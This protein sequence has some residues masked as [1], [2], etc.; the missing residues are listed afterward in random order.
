MTESYNTFEFL[1]RAYVEL[2]LGDVEQ[3]AR[4]DG[5]LFVV[6]RMNA[7]KNHEKA[8]IGTA[9]ALAEALALFTV[10]GSEGMTDAVAESAR[11][12]ASYL[13]LLVRASKALPLDAVVEMIKG[14]TTG[15]KP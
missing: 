9:E 11:E 8:Y 13:A 12:R 14:H 10:F 7:A 15:K 4:R 6:Q 3:S 5:V 2:A 1:E